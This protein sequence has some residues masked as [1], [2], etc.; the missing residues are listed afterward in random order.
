M[1]YP[2]TKQ[3]ILLE[4]QMPPG[5]MIM[6]DAQPI[7]ERTEHLSTDGVKSYKRINKTQHEKLS[8]ILNCTKKPCL[9]ENASV[10]N[11]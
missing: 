4:P 8:G 9:Q 1:E 6:V 10:K 2:V 11:R 3:T 5:Y 7:M